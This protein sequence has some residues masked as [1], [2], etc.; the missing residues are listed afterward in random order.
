MPVVHL[1]TNEQAL[2][3]AA[4]I[5]Q[6][7]LATIRR[8]QNTAAETQESG[9]RSLVELKEQRDQFV[10]VFEA[11]D[12]LDTGLQ[13]TEQLQNRLGLWS[14]RST[15][16][17]A[18]K[19]VD[20][21][22]A[23]ARKLAQEHAALAQQR[24]KEK[25]QRNNN[26]NDQ[27]HS[28]ISSTNSAEGDDSTTSSSKQNDKPKAYFKKRNKK[29]LK[30][31]TVDDSS[32]FAVKKDLLYGVDTTSAAGGGEYQEQL[33]HLNEVDHEIDA[34][35]AVVATQ[36]DT[37]L[38]MGCEIKNEIDSQHTQM[39]GLS[40]RVERSQYQQDIINKRT[41]K[42]LDGKLRQ[43]HQMVDTLSPLSVASK[44]LLEI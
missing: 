21:Q 7:T 18:K 25:Q 32:S 14:L 9:I 4:E 15:K 44:T 29:H 43:Q 5:Q 40:D 33:E 41:T 19:E 23:E 31:T 13:K 8:I 3:D 38:A 42:F 12:R 24:L 26:N 34:A 6:A 36:V 2:E 17:S 30:V 20:Q 37:I 11:A 10:R 35:L 39:E 27:N 22:R 1:E 28:N 16:T